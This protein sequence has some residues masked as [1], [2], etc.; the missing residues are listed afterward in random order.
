M[1][2]FHGPWSFLALRQNG[3]TQRQNVATQVGTKVITQSWYLPIF[4]ESVGIQTSPQKSV[5][6][7]PLFDQLYL[8]NLP[9]RL[10]YMYGLLYLKRTN[11]GKPFSPS[12]LVTGTSGKEQSW[13][14][15]T[16]HSGYNKNE[17]SSQT[18]VCKTSGSHGSGDAKFD[19]LQTSIH[20]RQ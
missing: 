3:L 12:S 4:E 1:G 6:N 16:A 17:E 8:D 19:G 20:R 14:T 18:H 10:F 7:Q 2:E 9:F 11:K 13:T 15:Y 5:A